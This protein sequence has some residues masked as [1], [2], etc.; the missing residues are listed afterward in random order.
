MR[1]TVWAL[2]ALSIASPVGAQEKRELPTADRALALEARDVFAVG[3]A[4]GGAE[5]ELFGDV[6]AV[7]FDGAGNLYVLDR[8][9][10][11]VR[12]FDPAGRYARTIGRKGSGPGELQAATSMTITRAGEV[13]VT[14]LSRQA[15]SVFRAN[16]DFV[17]NVPFPEGTMP[18]G[19]IRAHP[20]GGVTG[21]FRT[22]MMRRMGDGPP[23][24]GPRQVDYRIYHVPLGEGA[25]P[26]AL[27][28]APG[29]QQNVQASGSAGNMNV[30]IS[31]PPAFSPDLRWD[32]L[33]DGGVALTYTAGY[34]LAI[35]NPS[36]E[37]GH[38]IGRAIAPRTVTDEDR[39]VERERIR[40][41]MAS[42][43]GM[44]MV[45]AGPGGGGTSVGRAAAPPASA[46]AAEVDALEFAPVV[47][48]IDALRTDA[49]GR[50][51]IRRDAKAPGEDGPIDIV[52][53]DGRYLGTLPANVVIPDAFG[54][55]GRAA[56]IVEDDLG[57]ERVVVRT[58]AGPR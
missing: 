49:G 41:A 45:R 26:R 32:V 22:M 54:P 51:W 18:V 1:R 13:V 35:V 48:V 21:A 52:G 28:K 47:P 12:V 27:A 19:A 6:A 30:R 10:A 36:G 8:E 29:P 44:V 16:G 9:A 38:T 7:A 55:D 31:R 24:S 15:F 4:D 58:L 37:V 14:D 11:Q 17:R 3:R 57:V 33:N 46:I 5:W 53:P 2:V 50:L 39:E 34:S 56:Y 20:Q 42:G 23:Q 40:E 43:T 25:E